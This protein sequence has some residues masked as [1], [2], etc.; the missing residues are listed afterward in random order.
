MAIDKKAIR[1]AQR[2]RVFENAEK[3]K[4]SSDSV[5]YNSSIN[6]LNHADYNSVK[7]NNPNVHSARS[8]QTGTSYTAYSNNSYGSN[9]GSK[10]KR[11]LARNTARYNGNK[12][13]YSHSTDSS[14][15]S[16]A[17]NT[18]KNANEDNNVG[19]ELLTEGTSVGINLLGRVG[20][21]SSA[22]IKSSDL[23]RSI[24]NQA[25]TDINTAHITG[26]VSFNTNT[27]N[28]GNVSV[29]SGFLQANTQKNTPSTKSR[30]KRNRKRVYKR[31]Q[32]RLQSLNIRN[33]HSS[34]KS[35]VKA[36]ELAAKE[37]KSSGF[38]KSMLKPLAAVLF[39]G[40]FAAIMPLMMSA[41]F[42]GTSGMSEVL[43]DYQYAYPADEN[44]ITRATVHWQSL[45]IG[46]NNRFRD[47]PNMVTEP[48][49]KV[50]SD[51]CEIEDDTHKILSFLSAYYI[52]WSFNDDVRNFMTQIFNEM[53]VLTYEYTIET[54]PITSIVQVKKSELPNPLPENYKIVSEFTDTDGTEMVMVS[55]VDVKEYVVLNYAI[56]ET[57]TFDDI[58]NKYLT[59]NQ[60]E[61]Y[62]MYYERKGGAIKAFSSPFAFN[63]AN[64]ITSPFG[65]RQWDDGSTEFH[66]G[67]DFGVAEGTEILAVADGTLK[68]RSGCTHNYPKY[69]S[70]GCNGGFGNYVEITT[71]NGTRILYGHMLDVYVTDGQQ[72][73]NGQ[74]IGTVG[75]TGWSTG[76]HLHLQMVKDGEYIDPL[77]FIKQYEGNTTEE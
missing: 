65:Y 8:T 17:V 69:S 37:A 13:T 19:A 50:K 30:Y 38:F 27:I 62:L 14:A 31:L 57:A 16:Y 40:A 60:K 2:S 53:Y 55:I 56:T 22:V 10:P 75:C 76:F 26:N 33:K 74:A 9:S 32:E 6:Y 54:E 48:Y 68:V 77:T 23:S 51:K 11:N 47:V 1:K 73:K 12:N 58:V 29:K 5:S 70:C 61:D 3:A 41:I 18:L 36:K 28:N 34:K 66:K 15:A 71:E 7:S 24:G 45:I 67:V 21:S 52:K 59:D 72:I 46:L 42:S 64:Y 43:A 63:W 4:R 39:V 25:S 20:H 49:D 35:A 44:D